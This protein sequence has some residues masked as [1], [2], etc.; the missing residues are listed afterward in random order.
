MAKRSRTYI[1]QF[2]IGLGFLS[3]LWTAV[4]IDPE[5]VILNLLGK[6]IDSY[7]PDPNVR[8]LF[9]IL[10]ALLFLVSILTAYKKGG[11]PGLAAV[12]IAYG[13]G[14]SILVSLP[15]ALL[16]LF[17]AIIIGWFATSRRLI[18]KLTLK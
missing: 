8:T 4:G 1:G 3:G 9:L 7:Y 14:L 18:K 6:A 13:A 5:E 16:L 17:L 11:V 12:I 15:S 2:V 10:P